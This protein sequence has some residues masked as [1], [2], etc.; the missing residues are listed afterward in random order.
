MENALNAT[1]AKR[2]R[3]GIVL[4]GSA[5]AIA[6]MALWNTYRA[7]EIE[8]EHPPRGQF[9]T[10]DGV[11]IHY[12]E[13]GK[14]RP[15][16]LLHGNVVTAE[17]FELSGLLDLAAERQFHVVAFDRPGSGYSDRPR[18]AMWTP[19]RQADL[20]RQ[21]FAGLG[22]ERPI[23]VGHSW[24]TLVALA[25]ALDHPHAVSGLVLLSGYYHPTLRADVPLFS[26]PAI[27]VFGDLIRYT[28]GPLLGAALLPLAA[29]GMFSP[30]PVPERFAKG[31]PYGLPLRP[32]QIR[33]EAQD[34][35]TM[36]SA[37]RAMQRRYRELQMPV[38]I[39]AGTDDRVV[40]HR[41][42]AIRVH[43]EIPQ[44]VLRLVPGVGHMLHYA[45]PE[46]VV[47]A[48]EASTNS[49]TTVCS[50]AGEV[51]PP[52]TVSLENVASPLVWCEPAQRS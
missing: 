26:L 47:D 13:R 45:V 27:P 35:A 42:H 33:A 17:D 5:A 20:L 29:K 24:G 50:A 19:A 18:G 8:R 38:V 41:G 32:S 6:A 25:L 48:I 15:V 4:A 40:E 2:S 12:L 49:P 46:Q 11:R 44:S 14:G 31:F 22:I 34:T 21:A 36:V 28:V 37:V 30:L 43:Q 1:L 23:V 7:R 3:N 9:V 10:V 52:Q 51:G 16:V 39:M